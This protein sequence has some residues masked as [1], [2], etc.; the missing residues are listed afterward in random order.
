MRHFYNLMDLPTDDIRRLLDR[1]VAYRS[2]PH[3]D[4]LARKQIVLL[5]LNPSLRTRASF[6]V[7]I[8]ELGGGVSTL[9]AES[10]WKLETEAG[11]V[12][13]R[14]KAEHANEAVGVL[15]RY[16]DGIGIRAFARGVDRDED[17]QDRLVTAFM[18]RATVPVFNME[19][20]VYHP[21]QSLGDLLTIQDL[22]GDFRGH[23]IAITWAYH[24]RALPMAV[25]NSIL[26]AATRMGLDVTLAHPPEF[27][28]T[29]AI[30]EMARAY[31][32]T[33]GGSLRIEQDRL[34]AMEGAEIVYA[35]AWAGLKR[36]D[37]PEAE[38]RDRERYHSWMVDRKAMERTRRAYFMHCLPVRRNVVVSDEVIDS[39]A[40]VVLK[41][42]EN[43]LHAQKAILEWLYTG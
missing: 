14:D 23:R 29:D 39:A 4:I 26:L 8:R 41:Q 18:S 11:I 34:A 40:S 15:S 6:E 19:S 5:F 43:R 37:D 27:A 1:A 3:G 42:A 7:A 2:E 28:P 32:E 9:D 25:P 36:Y 24:P 17:F 35:K 13:D 30:L 33:S 38:A 31:T 12:M 22:L 16:F 21:C 20:A 10:L